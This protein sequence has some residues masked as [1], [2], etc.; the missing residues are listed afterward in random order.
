MQDPILDLAPEVGADTLACWP[1]AP[2]SKAQ[3][4]SH[5]VRIWGVVGRAEQ[6]WCCVVG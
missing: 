4:C 2:R 1:A 3:Q 6:V 5:L